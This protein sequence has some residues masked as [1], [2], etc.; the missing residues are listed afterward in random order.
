MVE[1]ISARCVL[2]LQKIPIKVL[3]FGREPVQYKI[4]R[5]SIHTAESRNRGYVLLFLIKA[6][7]RGTVEQHPKTER[8]SFSDNSLFSRRVHRDR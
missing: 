4:A 8:R 7:L 1:T 6:F 2:M 5:V 3:V